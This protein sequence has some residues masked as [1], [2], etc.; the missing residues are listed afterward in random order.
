MVGLTLTGSGAL[1]TLAD[2][3]Q[4]GLGLRASL[5]RREENRTRR[6]LRGAAVSG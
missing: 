1:Q 3:L 5:M 6:L 2:S 4:A